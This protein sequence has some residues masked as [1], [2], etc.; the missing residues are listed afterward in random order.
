[1]QGVRPAKQAPVVVKA[2]LDLSRNTYKAQNR[3]HLVKEILN[4]HIMPLGKGAVSYYH[5]SNRNHHKYRASM[6]CYMIEPL[7]SAR[8]DHLLYGYIIAISLR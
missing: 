1:M 3:T 8:N 4:A 2:I 6:L 7:T 5:L